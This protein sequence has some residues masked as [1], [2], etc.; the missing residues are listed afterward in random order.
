M[1]PK[2]INIPNILVFSLFLRLLFFIGFALGDDPNY[3]DRVDS[4]IKGHY[5]SLCETCVFA[6]R[7]ILLFFTALPMKYFGWSEFN[8]ILPILLSSLTSIYLIY[9]LG[10]FLFDQQTGLLAA[11]CLAIFPLNVVHA[12][13]M[14][15]DMMLSMFLALSMLLFLKGL[16]ECGRKAGVYLTL[17]GFV[18]GASI[19]VKIN[20]LPVV[21]LFILIALFNTWRK[22]KFKYDTI[23]FLLSWLMI[24]ALFVIVYYMKTGDLLAHIHAE[25]NFNNEYNPSSFTHTPR[26]LKDA[27]IYY[28][29]YML[30]IL[31]EGHPGYTFYPY[32]FFYPVFLLAVVFFLFKREKKVLIPLIWFFY[33]FL[34]MEFTPVKLSPYYQPIH[35][36]IRFLSIASIPALLVIAYF[37]KRLFEGRIFTK[38]VGL[39]LIAG[40]F[41]TSLHQA[42]RKS[43]FY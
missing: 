19:G 25:V 43:Y 14:S 24:Q 8:F 17:S 20:A 16:E 42:Y 15:N 23:L 41:F 39:L 9:A 1:N 11:F 12:T 7:P 32:G 31:S 21:G 35:R 33:L 4:I 29:K 2:W 22:K 27:L 5:P 38:L 3:A 10:R 28:P 6:F 26:Y 13:T 18:L 40:L 37:L 34:M 30:C 36:L